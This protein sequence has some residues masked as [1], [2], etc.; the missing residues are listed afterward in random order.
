[1]AIKRD[2]RK[3]APA[4][5]AE[6]RR[7]GSDGEGRQDADRSGRD[8]GGE[9]PVCRSMGQGGGAIGRGGLGGPASGSSAGRAESAERGAGRGVALSDRPRLSRSLRPV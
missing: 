8:S 3:L 7:R 5:Q 2:F 9:P 1:M 4:T 6:L